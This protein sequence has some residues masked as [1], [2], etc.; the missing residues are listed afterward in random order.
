MKQRLR[1]MLK[2]DVTLQRHHEMKLETTASLL[3]IL[4]EAVLYAS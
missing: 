4:I 3:M 2:Q 1:L